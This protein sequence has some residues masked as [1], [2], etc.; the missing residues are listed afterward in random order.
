M[1]SV[2]R[3][4]WRVCSM[5]SSDTT[6]PVFGSRPPMPEV[7]TQSPTT[8]ACEKGPGGLGASGAVTSFMCSMVGPVFVDSG[9]HADA[10]FLQPQAQRPGGSKPCDPVGKGAVA[11][12][13]CCRQRA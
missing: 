4:A 10:V 8:A 13:Q 12:Q 7:N 11:K 3:I 6:W 5:T 1:R 9:G 2:L